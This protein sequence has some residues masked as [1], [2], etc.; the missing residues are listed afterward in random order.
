MKL[1]KAVIPAAGLG[2]RMLPAAK[3]VAKELLPVLDRPAIQYVVEEAVAA[4]VTDVLLITSR[5]KRAIEDHFNRDPQ[6]EA[7]LNTPEKRKILASL[8]ALGAKVKIQSVLQHEMRG[9][10]D[11]VSQARNFCGNEP[12]LCM[13]GDAIF[14]GGIPP[15]VQLSAAFADLK[16]SVIGLE[17]VPPE[18]VHRYGIVGGT[19]IKP[20]VF[21]LDKIVE[22]TI[23]RFRAEQSGRRRAIRS[24]AGD[25][26]LPLAHRRRKLRRRNSIDRR[27]APAAGARADPWRASQR[28][29]PRHRRP[30]RLALDQSSLRQRRRKRLASPRAIAA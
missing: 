21:R 19:E 3:A 2:T 10:G 18:K 4:A 25:L 24:D 23:A 27:A 7:H 22:K 29:P 6:L 14:S 11:A 16:T 8:D 26:R 12:F 17:R 15:A 5:N 30:V 20:G 13:L 28:P 1:T 9:L